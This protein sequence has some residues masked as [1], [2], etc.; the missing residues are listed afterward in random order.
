M[1]TR[2]LRALV[3][4]FDGVIV[5]SNDVKTAAF[6]DVFSR[7]PE[8]AQAMMDFHHENVS[9]S[10]FS[11]FDHLLERLGRSTDELLR[12]ELAEEFS[13]RTIERVVAAPLVRGAEALLRQFAP[14]IPL[15]LASV[16]PEGDL[17]TILARRALRRWFR[18]VYGC[19]P[20]TKAEA[21]RD[22]LES[23]CC[24]PSEV[25]LVGD[26]AGDQRAALEAG[27]PFM[28]R[29]SGLPFDSPPPTRK[30]ADLVPIAENLLESIAGD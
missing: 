7:F 23:E 21:I 22:V 29:D 26:S 18:K 4:D 3:L 24:A 9:L 17:E 6:R 8:H 13:R 2:R 5:E 1:G 30:F 28:A 10:R 27:V 20:W 12:S 11:K 15:Y 25:L 19:P 14:R 16:T